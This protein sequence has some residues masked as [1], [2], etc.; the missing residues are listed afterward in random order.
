MKPNRHHV[1][2]ILTAMATVA[3]VVGPIKMAD[4][5]EQTWKV[6][7]EIAVRLAKLAA[8]EAEAIDR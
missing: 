8:D 4:M 7:C 6:V 5:H 1:Q 2:G 3:E